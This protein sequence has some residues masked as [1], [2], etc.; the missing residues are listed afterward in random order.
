MHDKLAECVK[1]E[2]QKTS[3]IGMNLILAPHARTHTHT[4]TM[5]LHEGLI[6]LLCVQA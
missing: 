6:C 2:E 5:A 4:H 1:T 3:F